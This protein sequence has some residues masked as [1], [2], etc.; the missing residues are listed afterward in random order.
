MPTVVGEYLYDAR[1]RRV[2]RDETGGSGDIT[3][4]AFL[5]GT[6]VAEYDA[7]DPVASATPQVEFVRA[8]GM[9]GGVGSV[10]YSLRNNV[11]S[12]T[13][14]NSRGDV[15]ARA[16]ATGSFTYT[17][18]YEAFGTHE[19]ETGTNP[20]RQQANTKEEDPTGLL[21]EGFR[22]RDLETGMFISRDPLG[23]VDGPNVY[24][25]VRQNPWTAFDSEG[26]FLRWLNEKVQ[27][28]A[29]WVIEKTGVVDAITN[30]MSEESLVAVSD[31]ESQN[32]VLDKIDTVRKGTETVGEFISPLSSDT[33]DKA[34]SGDIAGALTDVATDVALGKLNKVKALS[35]FDNVVAH[36][37]EGADLGNSMRKTVQKGGGGAPRSAVTWN[38]GWRTADGKFASPNGAGR[39]GAAAEQSVW[40]AVSQKPGWSVIEG[41]VG[42]RNASGQ[43]RYYDGAAVSPRGRVIGLEVKSGSATKT[44][45]QRIFDSGVNTQNPAVG[46]GRYDGV[47]EVGR[48]LEIRR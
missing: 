39:S 37:D 32:N 9:G 15:T 4:L 40:D 31:F 13:H 43:L 19:S 17:A 18:A 30:N 44:P 11:L 7:A 25:Y 6:S 8:N 36:V 47:L 22:Y 12:S 14:Y 33:L 10:L 16:D 35:K 21:N 5:G 38:N 20:D 24:T 41:Q 45:A 23:F 48:A 42:V 29:D 2:L 3:R 46:V 27:K 1:T 34:E 26:L 28:G